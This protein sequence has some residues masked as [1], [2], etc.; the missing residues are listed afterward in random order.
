MHP[1]FF[2]QNKNLPPLTLNTL[3][4]APPAPIALRFAPAIAETDLA[5]NRPEVARF[6]KQTRANLDEHG[7]EDRDGIQIVIGNFTGRT[8]L[9]VYLEGLK[10]KKYVVP[11]TVWDF[12]L[13]ADRTDH[14]ALFHFTRLTELHPDMVEAVASYAAQGVDLLATD[15]TQAENHGRKLDVF[16]STVAKQLPDAGYDIA[17]TYYRRTHG[18]NLDLASKMAEGLLKK[19]RTFEAQVKGES[20]TALTSVV[21]NQYVK[22]VYDDIEPIRVDDFYLT[23]KKNSKNLINDDPSAKLYG[24]FI[25]NNTEKS[26]PPRLG[27]DNISTLIEKNIISLPQTAKNNP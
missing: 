8:H 25:L 3:D 5:A 19:Q 6:N 15:R 1:D 18:L 10:H 12:D 26:K 7:F 17:V 16:L 27:K 23:S 24:T 13:R 11:K 2:N 4:I 21:I 9:E 14:D 22:P 20:I